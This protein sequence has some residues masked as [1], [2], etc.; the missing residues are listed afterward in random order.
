MMITG[1]VLFW[2]NDLGSYLRAQV[3]AVEDHVRKYM[4]AASLDQSDDEIVA[5][6]LQD[7]MVGSLS[8]DFD[9]PQRDVKE[10][11]VTVRD[12]FSGNVTID[13]VRVTKSFKFTG[14]SNLFNFRPSTFD[15][16]PPHGTVQSGRVILGY[17]GR[18]DPDSI[19]R[20]IADQEKQL[21]QYAE[22]SKANVDAHDAQLPALLKSSVER[23]RM[24]L[25]ELSKLSD[26]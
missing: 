25:Q 20:S 15:T 11:R 10:S 19:K 26:F 1:D 4:T 14:D 23:R 7:A 24:S 21:K 12:H 17:E 8:I 9:N 18:N 16:S 5:R 3:N 2:K 6:M 22:W 13:G